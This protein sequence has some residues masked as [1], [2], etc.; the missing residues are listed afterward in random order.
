MMMKK[1][2]IILM[3]GLSGQCLLAQ[4]QK[5]NE[6]NGWEFLEWKSGKSTV[7][8]LLIQKGIEIK[9]TY[10]DAAYDK[11]TRFEY[12]GMN[13]WLYFDSLYQLSKVEQYAEF[14]VIQDKKA[15]VFFGEVKKSLV[16]KYGEPNTETNDTTRKFITM[17][18]YLKFSNV[19]LTYDYKY[20]IIDEFGCCSYK[21]DIKTSP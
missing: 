1:I 7:E 4:V 5:P 19:I 21:V 9:D 11:I 15:N 13:T 18:W 17:N 6:F 8:K 3:I 20:K 12:D 10:S 14:S 2:I 16:Q